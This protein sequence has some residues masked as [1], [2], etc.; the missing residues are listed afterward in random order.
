MDITA[1]QLLAAIR[2]AD[3]EKH[4]AQQAGWINDDNLADTVLDGRFNFERVVEILNET[5]QANA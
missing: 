2:K 4:P 1:E 5:V 3:A